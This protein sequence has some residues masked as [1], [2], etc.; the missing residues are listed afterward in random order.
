VLRSGRWDST[1]LVFVACVVHL[2]ALIG[3]TATTK[4]EA[5]A[6]PPDEDFCERDAD[7]TLVGLESDLH[8][9]NRCYECRTEV[10]AASRLAV[11]CHKQACGEPPTCFAMLIPHRCDY[12]RHYVTPEFFL[13]VCIDHKCERVPRP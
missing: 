4:V 9:C 6:S 5:C 2:L 11:A 3:F 12:A 13:P 10:Y 8:S 1:P 7:C